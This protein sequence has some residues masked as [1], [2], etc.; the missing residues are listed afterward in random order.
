MFITVNTVFIKTGLIFQIRQLFHVA[1]SILD[2]SKYFENCFF[3]FCYRVTQIRTSKSM[4]N[5]AEGKTFSENILPL[6]NVS[7]TKQ[8]SQSLPSIRKIS[9]EP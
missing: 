9:S 6:W 3:I 1:V 4:S 5:L 7:L 2:F 8:W